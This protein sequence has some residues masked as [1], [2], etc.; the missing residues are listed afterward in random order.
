LAAAVFAIFCLSASAENGVPDPD[1]GQ[2]AMQAAI[3]KQLDAIQGDD[4]ASA[5]AY[6]TDALQQ[7]FET[8]ARFMQVVRE[9]FDAL[10]HARAREFIAVSTMNADPGL[11]VQAL[12]LTGPGG[13]VW[14]AIYEMERNPAG[15]WR[16]ARCSLKPMEGYFN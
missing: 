1:I 11:Q 9:H 13:H 2:V 15:D 16:V 5:F 4:E 3:T 6:N 7:H 10:Y 8:P 14:V 12:K